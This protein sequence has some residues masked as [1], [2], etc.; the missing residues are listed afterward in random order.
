MAEALD[1]RALDHEDLIDR[2]AEK[3]T[4]KRS[5]HYLVD[6]IDAAALLPAAL[7]ASLISDQQRSDC[8]SEA[9]PY[10]K[11]E[12]FVSHLQRVVN[13][14]STKFHTF[15]EVLR[16]TNQRRIASRLQSK[17]T[18]YKVSDHGLL[19]LRLFIDLFHLPKIIG[20]L[21][22]KNSKSLVN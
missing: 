14:D 20:W 13:G 17:R 8:A 11:A 21:T 2:N 5:F 22:I 15:L 12:K 6:S 3:E 9:D 16:R 10:K 7:S 4:L 1:I 19:I 18:M